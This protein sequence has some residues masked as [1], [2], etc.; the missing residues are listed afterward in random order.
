[1]K[2]III[3]VLCLLLVILN[4]CS[5][6][7][8]D[9]TEDYSISWRDRPMPESFDLRSVDTDGDGKGDR[10]FVT[11][12]RFQNPFGT[13]WGFAAIAAAEISILGSVEY[14]EPDAWKTL[15]LSEKQLA[16][17][18]NVALD[19]PGNP[20]NGEGKHPE[21]INDANEVYNTGGTGFLAT[22]TFGQGIGP[23]YEHKEE[24]HDYFVYKGIKSLADYR[25]LEGEFRNYSYSSSDDWTIPEEYRFKQDFI[26]TDSVILP[27]PASRNFNNGY[28]YYDKATTLIK[29]QL[30]DKRG[31]LIG[32]CADTSQPTQD[33]TEGIYIELNNWAHY[34]WTTSA[35]PNHAVTIIGW[36]DNYPKEN[37][38]AE[39]QPPD[40]GAWLVKNSWGSGEEDFPSSGN[41][42]WGI[43]VAKTD[44]KGNPVVDENGEPV[45]IGSGYFWLSYFDMSLSTPEAFCFEEANVSDIIDQYDYLSVSDISV[46]TQGSFIA[47]GNVFT[48]KTAQMLTQIS[49][50]TATEDNEVEYEVYILSDDYAVPEDGYL[51]AKG[52]I[53]YPHAG[54]HKIQL[55]EAVFLQEGQHY[56]ILLAVRDKSFYLLNMP[57]A[58]IL[59]GYLMNQTA[60]INHGESYIYDGY[61]WTD[62][63]DIVDELKQQDPYVDFGG[64]IDYDNFPI[65]GYSKPIAGDISLILTAEETTLAPREGAN[66]TDINLFFR[67]AANMSL[68]NPSITWTLL[69]GSEEILDLEPKQTGIGATVT[70]RK[71]GKG[72]VAATVDGVGTS[73][74]G[75]SVSRAVPQQY[76]PNNTV[77]EY[78]GQPLETTCTVLGAGNVKLI[79]NEDY[80]TRFSNNILCGIA[81]IELCDYEG[82]SFE[83][84]IYAHFG[85]RPQKAEITSLSADSAINLTVRDQYASGISGYMV[86]YSPA[87][88]DNWTSVRFT[89]GTSFTVNDL[90]SGSYDVR[91]RAYV[92][93]SAAEKDIYNADIYYGN[94]S[95]IQT[96]TVK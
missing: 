53:S 69:K 77:M 67:A 76:F 21:N 33:S 58:L 36:D 40:N 90:V 2:R 94:Y 78:T 9:S 92:D 27:S 54:F 85:I 95:D 84:A 3:S 19:D 8:P 28:A 14:H 31:V 7:S 39:H 59:K 75:I 89:D 66:K 71:T 57:R 83:P 70:A 74:I 42:H 64:K 63:A 18:T 37:F 87:G 93:V 91:V 1:M 86:E 81:T 29:E 24:Y 47:M 49:C 96:V 34:T 11:P 30:L 23:S 46:N 51:A 25:Y 45:M 72:Y 35:Q 73:I 48:A 20:Q 12:V 55:P 10:C 5:S 6:A 79:E 60:I 16:Y 68:G 43:P 22:A 15:D 56:S 4:G 17:F 82:N 52:K 88:I 50:V 80:T 26:M 32:F 62:Y 13:C 61:E 41:M 44:E 38:L 65:K